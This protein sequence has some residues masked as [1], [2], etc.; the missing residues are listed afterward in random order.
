MSSESTLILGPSNS[1]KTQYVKRQ[2]RRLGRPVVLVHGEADAKTEYREFAP[3]LCTLEDDLKVIIGS[4]I[5]VEDFVKQRDREGRALLK[6]L[7]YLKRH[8]N[9]SIFLN[10]YMLTS[11]GAVGLVNLFDR[12]VFT[13]HPANW[14]SMRIFSR[15]Y[16]ADELTESR[17]RS[18]LTGTAR[19][20]R[21]DMR[22][23]GCEILGDDAK[24][25]AI[26]KKKSFAQTKS[27]LEELLANFPE[28][29]LLVAVLSFIQRNIDLDSIVDPK[30]FSITLAGRKRKVKASL[31]DFLLAVRSKERP[32]PEIIALHQYFSRRFHLPYSFVSNNHLQKLR[33][34][35]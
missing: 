20:L 16:P 11:T 1:G 27:H 19:Y 30:D 25:A 14:K 29:E 35:Q 23:Q 24:S 4:A 28:H 7:G 26:S 8:Q 9:N 15:L 13:R 5:V 3:R 17:M 31:L 18:F 34:Q 33:R 6:M 21:I 10:T 12:V 2:L 22:S 32:S